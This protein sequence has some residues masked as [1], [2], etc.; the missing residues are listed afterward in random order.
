MA[1]EPLPELAL[2]SLR[3]D[4]ED[5]AL[6]FRVDTVRHADL[7]DRL[8]ALVERAAEPLTSACIA[9]EK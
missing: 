8:R 5:S 7:P 3:A 6:P 9:P 4:L 2:A 1:S